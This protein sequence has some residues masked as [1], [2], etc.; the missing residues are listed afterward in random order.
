MN[1]DNNSKYSLKAI[2]IYFGDK[3]SGYYTSKCEKNNNWY[4]IS[5]SSYKI[6]NQNEIKMLKFLFMKKYRKIGFRN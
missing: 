3:K 1:I 5:D 2:V 4:H 6:I